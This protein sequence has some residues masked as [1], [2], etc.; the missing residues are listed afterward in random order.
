MVIVMA[1]FFCNPL[2]GQE[3]IEI[4]GYKIASN[5]EVMIHQIDAYHYEFTVGKSKAKLKLWKPQ[6]A[7]NNSVEISEGNSCKISMQL[8]YDS[9]S[10]VDSNKEIEVIFSTRDSIT[11]LSGSIDHLA[12]DEI[13]KL[14]HFFTEGCDTI[15][16]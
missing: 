14:Y 3:T 13:A 1:V 2:F 10:S 16:Q 11:R 5:D 15:N 8:N 9:D 12:I 6:K 7:T 4:S